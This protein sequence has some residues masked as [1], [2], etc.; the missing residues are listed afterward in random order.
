LDG[1]YKEEQVHV[2]LS[3][4]DM[5]KAHEQTKARI[6]EIRKQLGLDPDTINGEVLDDDGDDQ[7]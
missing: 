2:H 4:D 1:A 3:Y 7:D 6:R 5:V